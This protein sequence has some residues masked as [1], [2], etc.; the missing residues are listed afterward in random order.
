MFNFKMR[1]VSDNGLVQPGLSDAWVGSKPQ[2][3]VL[4]K[5]TG[6]EEGEGEL[7]KQAAA[8]R[9]WLAENI[10]KK[11]EDPNSKRAQIM[12]ELCQKRG[13]SRDGT[14]G[15]QNQDVAAAKEG[16]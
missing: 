3:V 11:Y 9:D 4:A 10:V 1:R 2:G 7:Q 8:G 12:K 6:G 16:K 14:T 13:R 15:A 5:C